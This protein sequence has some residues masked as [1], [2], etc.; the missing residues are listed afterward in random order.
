M[1]AGRL[2]EHLPAIYRAAED[3]ALARLLSAFEDVLLGA[4]DLAAPGIEELLEGVE[5]EGTVRAGSRRYFDPGPYPPL[6]ASGVSPLAAGRDE[7]DQAPQEFL[8]WLGE[9]VALSRWAELDEDTQ[10]EF[11]ARAVSL[12]RK[13]GTREGLRE[14]IRIYTRLAPGIDELHSP[15]QVGVHS[16][17]GEDTWLG[18]GPSFFFRVRINLATTQPDEIAHQERVVRA[19]V[20]AE[21]PAHTHYALRVHTPSLQIGVHSRV[22]VDTLLGYSP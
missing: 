10:R 4:G 21:K 1:P 16:T 19:I 6:P 15:M 12:Y 22:G 20:D 9:W 2:R 14:V 13:R 11:I 17:I 8:S 5:V 7:H 3:D 18:G